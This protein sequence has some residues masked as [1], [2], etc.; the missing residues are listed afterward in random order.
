MSKIGL[1][2]PVYA[3]ATENEETSVISYSGGRVLAKAI[4]ADISIEKNDIK[5]YADDVVAEED[6]SFKSGKVTLEH[7]DLPDYAKVDLLGNTEGAVVD[8][9][10]GTKE[11][12]ASSSDVAPYVGFGFYGK[13]RV[14]GVNYWR[15]I[16]LKK[17]KFGEPADDLETRGESIAFKSHAIEGTIM[18]AVDGR[19]KEEGTF[20]TEEK[21]RN[22]LNGKAGITAKAAPVTSSVSSG[23]YDVTRS[24]VLSTTEASGTIYYTDDGTIPSETH[25]T[26]YTTAITLTG[27]SNTCIKAV[28]VAAGKADSDILELYIIVTE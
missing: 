14:R 18:E 7:D 28:C 10:I 15:A 17:V 22:W 9:A 25:G 12:I 16:W 5:L 2:Y 23:T 20:S 4:K 21:A 6:N 1:K 3:L 11:I 27:P 26:E 13:K 19:W 24:V 8:T